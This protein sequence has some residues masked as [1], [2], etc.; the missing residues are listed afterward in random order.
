MW[1]VVSRALRGH[2]FLSFYFIRMRVD[3]LIHLKDGISWRWKA[4]ETSRAQPSI[5]CTENK[6]D[7]WI[8]PISLPLCPASQKSLKHLC[9]AASVPQRSSDERTG[10]ARRIWTQDETA[11]HRILTRLIFF[12]SCLVN[13]DLI[14]RDDFGRVLCTIQAVFCTSCGHSSARF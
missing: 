8:N 5:Q 7:S 11:A 12:R 2:K 3:G 1:C 10:Y 6:R 9:L 13:S 14:L 4:P